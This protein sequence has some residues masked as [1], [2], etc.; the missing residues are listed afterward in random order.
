MA[1]RRHLGITFILA[2]LIGAATVG[3]ARPDKPPQLLIDES[4]AGDF[5]DLAEQT[6]IEF[7]AA[8]QARSDCFGDVQLQATRSLDSRAVY[9]PGTATVTVRVPGTPALLRAAL[10][11]EWAHHIEFQCEQHQAHR[12]TFLAALDLPPN[13]PWRPESALV[14]AYG[15][16]GGSSPSERYAEAIIVYVLGRRHIATGAQVTPEA[17]HAIEKWAAGN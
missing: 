17:V 6:W 5:Q 1:G 11:H 14:D 7:L 15:K 13:T 4:V 10:V 16:M 12:A 9:D 2:A 8:F 3:C